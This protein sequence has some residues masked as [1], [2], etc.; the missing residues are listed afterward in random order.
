MPCCAGVNV[1]E[2]AVNAYLGGEDGV[3]ADINLSEGQ[4]NLDA[5]GYRLD[6]D[7]GISTIGHGISSGASAVADAAGSAWDTV[8]DW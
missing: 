3:G 6:V 5:F 4:F 1:S 7:E 2:G 8:S